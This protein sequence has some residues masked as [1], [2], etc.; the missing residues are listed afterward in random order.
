MEGSRCCSDSLVSST[1]QRHIIHSVYEIEKQ[2]LRMGTFKSIASISNHEGMCLVIV[3]HAKA[4]YLSMLIVKASTIFIG[5]RLIGT[6]NT[7][8]AI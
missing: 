3:P 5:Y 1:V 6:Q 7:R 4:I 8:C 2:S